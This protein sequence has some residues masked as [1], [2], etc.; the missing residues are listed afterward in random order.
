MEMIANTIVWDEAFSILFSRI[1]LG[2]KGEEED[3]KSFHG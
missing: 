2:S 1:R 3:V